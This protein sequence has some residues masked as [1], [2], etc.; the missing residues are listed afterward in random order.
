[1]AP[2]SAATRTTFAIPALIVSPTDVARARQELEVFESYLEAQRIRQPGRAVQPA[3]KISR[4][5]GSFVD[6]NK[7]NL[8]Q[9]KER[10]NLALYLR[11]LHDQA[12]TVHISF[13]SEPSFTALQKIVV[14]LRQNIEADILVRVGIQPSLVAG[15]TVRTTNRYFDFSLRKHLEERRQYLINELA[16]PSAVSVPG[17]GV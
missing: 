11:N 17:G 14:W 8:L 10:H 3:P 15:C 9:P 6:Q 5:L 1:V 2:N 12:P 7:I 13:A 4:M 16:V